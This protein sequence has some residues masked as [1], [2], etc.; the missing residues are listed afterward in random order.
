MSQENPITNPEEP[1]G[2]TPQEDA[3]NSSEGA[4]APQDAAEGQPAEAAPK[5]KPHTKAIV[6]TVCIIAVAAIAAGAYWY[7]NVKVPHDD[8]V[9]TYNTAVSGL[10]ERNAEL[11]SAISDLQAVI[12]S[13]ETP[14]DEDLLDE[15]SGV[16]GEAQGAREEAPEQPD[17]T[18]EILAAAESI[19]AMGDYSEEL[20]DLAAAQT[21]LEDSIAQFQLVDNPTEQYV[22]ECIDG[23]PNIT[24]YEAATED[25]DPN[26][27]LNKQGGYT[28]A[29]FFSSDL[30]DQ[31]S[32][33]GDGILGKGTDGGG[34]IEVYTT[35]EDAESRDEYLGAFD[36]S[37]FSSG[38]HTVVG[39]VVVRTSDELTASEQQ[40]MTDNIIASLTSLD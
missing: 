9:D 40:E 21:E 13:G 3:V 37:V 10:E 29:V 18:D 1:D 39:T 24:G 5:K 35:V 23:L 17:S 28:A 32:V 34:C 38:S 26:G 16:I 15:A 14:L 7:V 36:G 33:Y 8:A 31:D 11:D 22:I 27:N 12:D 6:I 25:N 19:D 4:T 30:V 20:S 2:E